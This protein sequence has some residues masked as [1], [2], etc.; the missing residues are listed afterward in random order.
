MI[1][2]ILVV[3]LIVIFF[4]LSLPFF[5]VE[6]LIGKK[7]PHA[8]D[9][10]MLRVAQA[11]C[12]LLLFVSGTKV[13]LKGKEKIPADQ[14]VLYI[15][16]HRSYF[17]ILLTLINCPGPT[18]YIGKKEIAIVPVLNLWLTFLHGYFL[19]REDLRQALKTILAAID[20]VKNG[21]SIAIFPEGT[22][23]RN[24]KD[25]DLLEFHEGSF[26][27]ASKTGCPIIPVAI[28]GSSEI[29]EKHFPFI[30]GTRVVVEYGDP[31]LPGELTG[32]AKKFTGRYVRDIM[33]SILTENEKLLRADS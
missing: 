2:T 20:E 23:N 31:V 14:P 30:R 1:R 25:T 27:I 13:I 19:D 11:F 33:L 15:I 32:D 18:G 4:I 16:N 5:L 9:I 6:W 24:E 28:S 8:R 29:L 10:S 3:I 17:D 22:R 7:W 21:V 26:K 12:R